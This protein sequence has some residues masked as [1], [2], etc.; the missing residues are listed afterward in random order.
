MVG[1]QNSKT[2]N[3]KLSHLSAYDIV[4]NFKTYPHNNPCKVQLQINNI[5]THLYTTIIYIA[6][7]ESSSARG[8]ASDTPLKE[9]L[10]EPKPAKFSPS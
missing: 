7:D 5:L 1:S 8:L 10:L 2:T 4:L 3:K 9:I 6:A